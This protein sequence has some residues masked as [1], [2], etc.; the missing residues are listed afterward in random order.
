MPPIIQRLTGIWQQSEDKLSLGMLIAMNLVP[1]GGAI[2]ASWDVGFILLV[3]WAE[4]VVLGV[5]N[6]AK[7]AMAQGGTGGFRP[8]CIPLI[9]F[10]MVHYGMFC[11][12]HGIFVMVLGQ[13][14]MPRGG[15]DPF[16]GLVNQFSG[17]LL[18]PVLGLAVSH[19]VSFFQNYIGK[20][21]YKDRTAGAQMFAPYGRI[22]ILHVVI[23]FGGF[24]VMLLKS[25]LPLLILLVLIKIVI[26]L[27]LHSWSHGGKKLFD[28]KTLND[29]VIKQHQE[30]ARRR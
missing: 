30:R 2:F 21:E 19:G 13:G 17:A 5:I 8:A 23:L 25:P 9:P 1:L 29:Q 10:F 3:Y 7:L 20:G 22:V 16:N 11:F 26:D 12:V 28:L 4:N 6:I 18:W 24:V 27:G 14:G 15:F